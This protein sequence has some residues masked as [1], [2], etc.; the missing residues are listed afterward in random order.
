MWSDIDWVWGVMDI[1]ILDDQLY[2]LVGG[3][4]AIHGNPESPSGVYRVNADGTTEVIAD[5]GTWVDDNPVEFAPP[6]G[7]PNNGSFFAMVANAGALWVLESVNGQVL[8]VTQGREISRIADLSEGHLVPTGIAADPNGGAWIGYLTTPPYAAGDA[9]IS[10]V[11]PDG[12]VED[13]WTGLQA[14]TG[15]ALGPDGMLYAAEMSTEMSGEGVFFTRDTGR[16]V[17]QSGPAS[18]ED[19]ATDLDLPVAMRFGPDGG[20]YVATPA[21]GSDDGSGQV[22]RIEMGKVVP[23]NISDLATPVS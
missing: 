13:A 14:V 2:A 17:R 3:G 12:T 10:H 9:K 6:E 18:A 16:I 23:V 20:L 22:L 21:F 1:A 4:G 11:A 5:L 15:V 7:V 19:V 8:Q